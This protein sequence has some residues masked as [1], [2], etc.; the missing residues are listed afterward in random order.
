MNTHN[1][2]LVKYKKKHCLIL[3]Y[4]HFSCVCMLAQPILQSMSTRP[5]LQ[6]ESTVVKNAIFVKLDAE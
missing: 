2:S 1:S 4:F 5:S 6:N 3:F